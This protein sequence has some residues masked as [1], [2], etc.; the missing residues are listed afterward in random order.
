MCGVF[1]ILRLGFSVSV[2]LRAMALLVRAVFAFGVKRIL[3]SAKSLQ[4]VFRFIEAGTRQRE[5]RGA[6]P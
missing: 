2:V 6:N 5:P 3:Q 4:S 1:S